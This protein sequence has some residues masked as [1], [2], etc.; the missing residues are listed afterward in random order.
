MPAKANTA[1]IGSA[2][3]DAPVFGDVVLRLLPP[4]L[5]TVR[6]TVV[7]AVFVAVA[8]ESVFVESVVVESVTAGSVAAGSVVTESVFVE[9]VAVTL[10]TAAIP[11]S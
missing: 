5:P 4:V 3:S 6:I 7:P 2:G 10:F 1:R 8:A 11:A 9:S